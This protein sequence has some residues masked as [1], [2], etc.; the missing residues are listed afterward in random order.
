[1]ETDAASD[2]RMP[3]GTRIGPPVIRVR[4]MDRSIAF[5]EDKFGLQ[6]VRRGHGID[7]LQLTGLR[8]G[9]GEGDLIVL[10]D[11]PEA[12][13]P[14]RSA[15]GLYHFAV[16]V[17]DRRSLAQ[18]LLAISGNGVAFEGFADHTVSESLYLHDAEG[19]GIEIYSDRGEDTWRLFGELGG[20]GGQGD[21]RGWSALN[22]P[23][24]I[25]SLVSEAEGMETSDLRVLPP[26]T[27]MGH[28][29]LKVTDLARSL[30]FYRDRLGFDVTASLPGIGAAFLS[31]GGYHHH[32][33]LNTW[34]SAG[35]EGRRQHRAGLDGFWVLLPGAGKL[36]EMVASLGL[37]QEQGVDISLQDPD[38]IGITV[39]V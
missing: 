11:D 10:K 25:D 19:N 24:D 8:T 3:R 7:G 1:M 21:M 35:G 4:D 38:G 36:G 17:P 33:G 31:A 16:R 32:I 37:R 39:G 34:Q 12:L 30:S 5:Y 22:R 29:H 18:S 2:F 13:P 9:E 28:M 26:G 20:R 15:A 6:K 27:V 14:P 23:L